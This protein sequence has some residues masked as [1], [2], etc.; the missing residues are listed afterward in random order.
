MIASFILLAAAAGPL[1][2]SVL[3][4]S[5]TQPLGHAKSVISSPASRAIN[6][7]FRN[8]KN[9]KSIENIRGAFYNSQQAP[10]QILSSTNNSD[11]E[12]EEAD[13]KSVS[14]QIF[15]AKQQAFA[16]QLA[17]KEDAG[18]KKENREKFAARRLAL[19]S[20]TFYFSVLI[21]SALWLVSPNPF[22]TISYLFGALAGTAYSY[23]LG[24][25]V[26]TIGGSID[27]TD[28]EGAGVGQARFAFLILLFVVVGKFRS[29][30]LV[31]I[32]SIMGFFTYQLA[33]L[34]QGLREIDD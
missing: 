18:V 8:D 3:A 24:K 13:K 4:F 1:C 2:P 15:W 27:D 20:D 10:L 12:Q 26:E 28:M 6:V 25:Y 17:A 14:D 16:A 34:N 30:G 31:E 11:E 22:V 21:A 19:T 7:D 23:G 9:K 5:P 29:Q 33:S 32:P